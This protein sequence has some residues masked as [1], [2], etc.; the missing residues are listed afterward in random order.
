M[1]DRSRGNLQGGDTK[2][3]SLKDNKIIEVTDPI[4]DIKLE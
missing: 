1:F 3:G 4:Q 2:D